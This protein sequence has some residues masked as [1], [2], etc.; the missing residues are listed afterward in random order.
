MSTSWGHRKNS[1]ADGKEINAPLVGEANCYN[2]NVIQMFYCEKKQHTASLLS[3]S[4]IAA[5]SRG[6]CDSSPTFSSTFFIQFIISSRPSCT[7]SERV[8]VT[9]SFSF[10]SLTDLDKL[11]YL[12]TM[13]SENSLKIGQIL[14]PPTVQS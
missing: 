4:A 5:E 7:L 9:C 10:R 6:M 12:S 2:K 11:S 14:T 8:N 1:E 13:S 3:A